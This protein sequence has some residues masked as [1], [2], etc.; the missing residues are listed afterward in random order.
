MPKNRKGG[1]ILFNLQLFGGSGASLGKAHKKQSVVK[2]AKPI[3]IKESKA[4]VK[5]EIK[6]KEPKISFKKL[7]NDKKLYYEMSAKQSKA[8]KTTL[9]KDERAAIKKYTSSSYASMNML[10]RKG[11]PWPLNTS[12]IKHL[13]KQN[14]LAQ[15]GL[16]KMAKHDNLDLTLYR[17]ASLKSTFGVQKI[18]EVKAGQKYDFKGFTSTAVYRDKAWDN[19]PG[20]ILLKINKP[21]GAQGAFVKSISNHPGE[22]EYLLNHNTKMRVDKVVGKTVYLTVLNN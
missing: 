3:K 4:K 8:L 1:I 15:Q 2:E 20:K 22:E 5:T 13:R 9:D 10:L 12:T 6:K 7:D 16:R 11:P 18:S 14:A 21:K 17:G 19:Q